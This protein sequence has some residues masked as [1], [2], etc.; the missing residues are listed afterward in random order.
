MAQ[1]YRAVHDPTIRAYSASRTALPRV[2]HHAAVL[3]K[4]IEAGR[5]DYRRRGVT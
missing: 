2:D 5:Y 1:S 4:K 3:H